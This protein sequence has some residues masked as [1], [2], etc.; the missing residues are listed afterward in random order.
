MLHHSKHLFKHFIYR[1]KIHYSRY[2]FNNILNPFKFLFFI[3]TNISCQSCRQ[4]GGGWAVSQTS[5]SGFR[6]HW[7]PA[8]TT[9]SPAIV[10]PSAPKL[11]TTRT[12]PPPR[13]AS[14][15]PVRHTAEIKL[16][17][18]GPTR[19]PRGS[20]VKAVDRRARLLP[21]EYRPR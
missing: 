1:E 10:G 8:L 14:G 15:P 16:C 19:Y 3:S 6:C 20:Q 13:L 5:V 2:L 4:T 9:T 7:S 18:A 21:G 12:P 17:S 11:S